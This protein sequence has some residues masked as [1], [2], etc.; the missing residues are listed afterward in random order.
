MRIAHLTS[1]HP[2]Y[3]TRIFLKECT[4]L[5]NAG[6]EVNL[7]VAD[8]Q[9]DE[10]KNGVNIIDT[11]EKSPNRIKRMTDTIKKVCKEAIVTNAKIFHIH[12]PE[13]LRLTPMLLKKGKVIYDA[14]EDL[15]GQIMFKSWI[16]KPFRFFVS[17]FSE[18]IE[19]Y[20]AA[21]ASGI[22]TAGPL[23]AGRLRKIN[24]NLEVINNFPLLHEFTAIDRFHSDENYACYV[25]G[26]SGIR[27][28]FEMVNAMEKVDGKLFLAGK[29]FSPEE[30][31]LAQTFPGWKN[32][33]E[34]GFCNRE[35]LR[36]IFSTAKVALAFYHPV[37][38]HLNSQSNKVF[39]YMVAGLPVIASNLPLFKDVIESSN[40][41]I[42]LDS[43]DP[44][45]ISSSINYFFKNPE[46]ATAMGKNG[47]N[48]I[49]AQYNWSREE[50][51]L[52]SFYARLS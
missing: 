47:S 8:G 25:G 22:L 46:I 33:I 29:F 15:P 10:K 35:K 11:G 36:E 52:L 14:H 21:Q 41:G 32:I 26:I 23:I 38:Y 19:N 31:K 49:Q 27:G 6:F 37:P 4:S 45:S 17:H 48:A 16:P 50:S 18:K 39:E 12:D 7:I 34:L 20:Y 43:L 9:G 1:V 51:K 13:L 2:R 3:D 40:C 24:P 44:E 28:I 42:C 5:A 30:K